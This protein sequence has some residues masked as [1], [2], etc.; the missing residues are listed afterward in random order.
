MNQSPIFYFLTLTDTKKFIFQLLIYLIKDSCAQLIIP[1]FCVFIYK[2]MC[3]DELFTVFYL[4]YLILDYQA[5][6]NQTQYL[7]N[8]TLICTNESVTLFYVF[9]LNFNGHKKFICSY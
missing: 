3:T 5:E 2:L 4:L 8:F 9:I 7:S 1:I 6:M